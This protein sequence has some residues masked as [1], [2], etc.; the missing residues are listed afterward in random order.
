MV[1]ATVCRN[2]LLSVCLFLGLTACGNEQSD[3]ARQQDS[4]GV[5]VAPNLAPVS[6]VERRVALVIGNDRYQHIRSLERAVSD[7]QAVGAALGQLGFE[8]LAH[9]NLERRGMNQAIGALADRIARGGVGVLF[10]AGHGVQVRGENFLLPIDV[11]AEREE[12]LADEAIAFGR[13]MERLAQAQAKFTLLMLD[14]CRDNPFPPRVAGRTIGGTRGLTIPV[15]PDGLMVI[16][17]AGINEQALDRL[18]ET[19]ADPNGLF[20]RELL[21]YLRQPGVRVDDMLKQVRGA[22]RTKAAEIGHT[23]S[24]AFYDQSSGDFYFLRE[25]T[26]VQPGGPAPR[27]GTDPMA[28]E[29]AFWDS[30]RNSTQRADF[31]EY[32]KQYPHGRFVGLAHNR[33]ASLGAAPAASPKTSNDTQVVG[34]V[35]P[36][37]QGGKAPE[38]T[39][40]A[41]GIY[42]QQPQTPPGTLVGNDGAEMVLVPAGEFSM[43]SDG[44]E[45]DRLKASR[46][47]FRD[48]IPRHRVYL[49]TFYIDKYEVTNARFQQ[50]V[51]ATGHRTRARLTG[52]SGTWRAPRGSGSSI[53]GLEQHPVVQVSQEDAKAY[54]SWA[55]K[56][57]PTEAEWEKAARGTDGQIYPWGNQFDGKRANFCDANCEFNWKDSAAN[58]GYRYTAPVGNYE[59]GKSP[60]GAYDMAGNVWEWVSDWHDANYYWNSP[61]RNPQGPASGD[62]AVLRGGGWSAHALLVRAPYRYRIAPANQFGHSGFRCA[63]TL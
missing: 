13:I 23:Q 2:L 43:G 51:Q 28:V 24:P 15:A 6:P 37:L 27:P 45:L 3:K 11:K 53:A 22:V 52:D 26:G 40:V 60:Y 17:S 35:S 42:P 38:G 39:Q 9:A 18:S 41:V 30:V 4:R 33:L 21:K 12:D 50:F 36:Q 48:E 56:R 62:L 55:G 5:T 57:L 59:G 44:D 34:G 46:E 25:D 47:T 49:D 32:L 58:D 63:K 54:C 7:A 16:Y 8:V 19:D 61:A 1:R 20:T 14:A 29:L 10:F 31:E